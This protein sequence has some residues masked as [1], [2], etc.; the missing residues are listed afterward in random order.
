MRGQ[1]FPDSRFLDA[2]GNEEPKIT[3]FRL[4]SLHRNPRFLQTPMSATKQR[5]PHLCFGEAESSISEDGDTS[6]D[7]S[8]IVDGSRSVLDLIEGHINAQCRSIW[9]V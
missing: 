8:G 2:V 1:L 4:S 5:V 3:A 7:D 6:V 9:A